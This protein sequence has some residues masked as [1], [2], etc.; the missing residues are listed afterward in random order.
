MVDGVARF[1]QLFIRVPTI[2]KGHYIGEQHG[3]LLVLSMSFD[4]DNG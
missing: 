3:H 4:I 1:S 2:K